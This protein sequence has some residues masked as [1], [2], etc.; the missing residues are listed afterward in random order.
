[1]Q[2]PT[3]AFGENLIDVDFFMYQNHILDYKSQ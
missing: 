3:I 1:M 2:T